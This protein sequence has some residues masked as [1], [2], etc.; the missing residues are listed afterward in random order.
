MKSQ[1]AVTLTTLARFSFAAAFAL[2]VPLI[3]A[4]A[5]A[6][7]GDLASRAGEAAWL[8]PAAA[9]EARSND[10]PTSGASRPEL[11]A[12]P[13]ADDGTQ[14]PTPALREG[15]YTGF[16][17]NFT[18]V[19]IAPHNDER[20]GGGVDPE[21]KYTLDRGAVRLSAGLRVG[22]YYARNLFGITAMPTLR[23]VVPV[24]PV[25]PYVSFGMGYGWLPKLEHSGIATMSR[26]GV[27]FRFSENFGLGVEGTIQK[28]DRSRFEFPSFGSAMTLNF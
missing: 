15:K 20:L 6:A 4:V 25:E 23:L 28:I 19:L 17:L 2:S 10:V 9:L 24:G 16:S 7:D 8:A 21:L 11:A 1:T 13:R 12:V 14:P 26:L 27:V 22:G 5:A 18:P 3:P